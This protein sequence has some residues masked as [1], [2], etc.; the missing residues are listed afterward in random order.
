[1]RDLFVAAV[2]FG[3][4]PM[5]FR[6]PYVGIYLWSWIGYHNPHRLCFGW[7][8][9]FPWALIIA[10]VTLVA[11]LFSKEPKRIP[12]T[13]ETSLLLVFMLWILLTTYFAFYADAA[14][15]HYIKFFKI[16]LMTYVTM[17]AVNTRQRLDGFIW[18]ICISLG[19]YGIKGGIFTIIHGGVHHVQGPDGTFFG[20][21]NEMALV[22]A[23]TI[24]LL[25]YLR[26]Q[27]TRGWLRLGLGAAMM[28]SAIAAIGS[29]SRG[30][31]LGLVAM[32][33][34]LWLKTRNKLMTGL[35]LVTSVIIIGSIMPQAWYDRMNTI[36]TYDQDD[37]SLGRINAWWTAWNVAK[38]RI[39][40]GGMDMFRPD[41]FQRYAP[42]PNNVHD[43]HSIYFE[44][45][46]EQGFIGLAMFLTLGVMTW[47]R[48]N[49]IKKLC[50]KD[51]E[52]KWA[53]DLA[54]MIQVSLVGYY[55]AGTFL[56]LSYFDLFYHMIAIVVMLWTF[57]NQPQ[58]SVPVVESKA[59]GRLLPR[60]FT[61]KPAS[62]VG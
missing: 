59:R 62:G 25:S 57:V 37:S 56:G 49:Q 26:T 27:E 54:A 38:I 3:F 12:W 20:G 7:A 45:M 55:T 32:G 58:V 24:P 14:W 48:C 44:Q 46:G 2:V 42:D 39:T 61:N 4:L 41:T 47:Q 5:A 1:M 18:I 34:F 29:Q 13:R 11:L 31:L 19:F 9:N 17:I 16:I 50:K 60:R 40:G 22:L 52:R 36:K 43:V 10:L 33:L 28:L 21:N 35:M 15:E 53:A 8:L 6:K 23:M 30:G 51:P